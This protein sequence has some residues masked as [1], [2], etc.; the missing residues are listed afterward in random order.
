[1]REQYLR[2]ALESHVGAY[3]LVL[4]GCL[5][6]LGLLTVNAF[7]GAPEVLVDCD[8]QRGRRG[9][10][11]GGGAGQEPPAGLDRIKMLYQSCRGPA[12]VIHRW[13]I[14]PLRVFGAKPMG[15]IEHS[16]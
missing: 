14:W 2:Q 10:N 5:P 1:M 7:C 13:A 8:P 4:I 15:V 9:R 11:Q 3:D 12:D 16:S 6:N